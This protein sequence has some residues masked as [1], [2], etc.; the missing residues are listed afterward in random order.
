M[1]IRFMLLAC[2]VVWSGCAKKESAESAPLVT[3]QV[4]VAE[5]TSIQQKVSA[6]AV[7]YPLRQAAVTPKIA[8]PVTRYYVNRGSYVRAGQLMAQ[9]ENQDLLAAV[10]ESQGAYEQAQAAYET[11]TRATLPEEVQKA[12]LDLKAAQEAFDAQQK[13][14]NSRQALFKQ[15]AI[16]RRDLDDTAVAYTQARNQYELA[17]RHLEALQSFGKEQDL[18]AA[19]GQLTAAKGKYLGARTQLSYAE[20]RSPIDGIVADRPLNPGEMAAVGSPLI[21]VM[22]L[23]QVIARAHI[24]QQEAATLRV[25]DAASMSAPGASDDVPGKV[26]VVS[27]ALDPN[28]TTV[29]VWV[30]AANPGARLRPGTSVRVTIVAKTVPNTVVIPARA[31]LT[32]PDGATSVI[33][34]GEGDKPELKAVKTGIRNADKVQITDGLTGGERVVTVGA[35]ELSREDPDVLAQTKLH[36]EAPK[37]SGEGDIP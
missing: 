5:K 22:D 14:Y 19:A 12:E 20:I 30:Q 27:P 4:A 18:K 17:K 3:V 7:L 11:A 13:I 10:T 34:D 16:A 37:G 36:V 9:L 29:E 33:L 31:L 32:E 15:G 2:S 1:T 23:S 26:T 24:S 25:G 8:A 35:F 28:S 21:T 6:E